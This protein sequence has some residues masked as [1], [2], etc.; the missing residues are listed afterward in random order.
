MS[1]SSNVA[2]VFINM[3]MVAGVLGVIFTVAVIFGIF[4]VCRRIYYAMRGEEYVPLFK[5]KTGKYEHQDVE[6]GATVESI[7]KVLARYARY[8]TVGKYAHAGKKALEDMDLKLASFYATLDSKFP[9]ESLSWD[10]F[11]VAAVGVEQT[12]INN[13]ALLANRVQTFDRDEYRQLARQIRNAAYHQGT[14]L[15]PVQQQKWQLLK[16]SIDDMDAI[17][18]SNEH[19]LFELD[20]LASELDKL[21]NAGFTEESEKLLEEI[22][23]LIDETKYYRQA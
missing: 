13:C 8:D 10:K 15:A 5:G 11:S 6:S 14:P 16:A 9:R 7:S 2:E 22:R 12:L 18:E 4:Y 20:K 19:L 23:T 1:A 21:Q 17:I 3:I